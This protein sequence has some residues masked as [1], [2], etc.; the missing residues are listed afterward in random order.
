MQFVCLLCNRLV[1]Y[2][3]IEVH[4]QVY[5]PEFSG[6]GMMWPNSYNVPQSRNLMKIPIYESEILAE[7]LN[8][9]K[10]WIRDEGQNLSGSMKDYSTERAV[11]L[12]KEAGYRKVMV[13]S[14]GNHAFSLARY[15][16]LEGLD[17]I[18][19]TPSSSSKIPHLAAMENVTVVALNDAIFEDVY[20]LSADLVLDGVYNANVSN[21]E[22]LPGF[23]PIVEDLSTNDIQP[24]YILAG[25]GNGSYLAG[26]ILAY[27][28]LGRFMPKILP[29]GMSGAFPVSQ[30]FANDLMIHEHNDFLEEEAL[31]DAAEGS[32]AVASYSMPQLIHAMKLS[33][34]Q[35]LGGLLNDNLAEAYRCLNLDQN[36]ISRGVIPEPTGIMGLASV[37]KDNDFFK[38]EDKV[39]VSFTGNGMKDLDGIRRLAP[40][41]ADGFEEK[42]CQSRPD[43]K[44]E[45]SGVVLGKV[46]YIAKETTK[47]EL[48][49]VLEGG[50]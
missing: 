38:P 39:M 40:N 1:S 36:L 20:R 26:I 14:C 31:I 9:E 7:T 29:V 49:R 17:A 5:H 30:A 8:V 13:V 32:I 11:K 45:A 50:T 16:A 42:L 4:K 18:C 2:T 33:D 23:S 15:A 3:F 44:V 27:Q 43:L 34:G 25:A 12:A 47:E 10:V 22:L 48:K 28:E 21:E 24:D 41:L 35:P 46:I 6:Y 37:M 19:F